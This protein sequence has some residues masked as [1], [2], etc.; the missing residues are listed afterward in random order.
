MTDREIKID[1]LRDAAG[2]AVL[3]S[4]LE[5]YTLYKPSL[6]VWFA[7]LYDTRVGGFYY[8]ESARD[9][10]S[11][12]YL[13]KVY[14]L[15]PDIESTWQALG[16]VK[17]SGISEGHA[18]PYRTFIPDWMKERTRA[19]AESLADP[20]GFYYHPQW[21]KEISNSRRARDLGCARA[22]V[23]AFGAEPKYH[24][25]VD[26]GNSDPATLIP[27]HLSSEKRFL[28]YL[29]SLDIPNRSYHAGND[30]IAQFSQI[31]ALGLTEL[32]LSYLSSLQHPE[33]GHWHNESSYYAVN[34][35]MKISCVYKNAG[36]PL[37]NA[38]RA[39]ISAI[40]AITSDVQVN[41]IT[42]I[43]NTWYVARNII[44][45]MRLLGTEGN[46][47]AD[48]IVAE[49]R[50]NA[51]NA[52][53]ATREKVAP[54]EKKGGSFSYGVKWPSIISQ[55]SPVCIPHLPEGDINGTVMASNLMSDIIFDT[56]ELR[57]Y[58]IP[59]LTRSAG[60]LFLEEL[61]RRRKIYG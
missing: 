14:D 12:E 9:N 24:S 18:D 19:F 45:S 42:E 39:A 41:G 16:F 57:D 54:F 3:E 2:S 22:T 11:V 28:E 40:D 61:E 25:V 35:L 43:W 20:D 48:G 59:I 51:P 29:D 46:A 56:L 31:N 5:L 55:G 53:R 1:R 38:N 30:L 32:C 26:G 58:S 8:S 47:S 21:G 6:A 27:E 15:L 44:S 7:S 23:R 37:P 36:V 10:S 33:T 4:I 17:G 60:D 50:L 13:G 52:I 34:G 49:L